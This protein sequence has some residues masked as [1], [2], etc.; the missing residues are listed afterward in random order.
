MQANYSETNAVTTFVGLP[1]LKG[2]STG[3]LPQSRL[4]EAWSV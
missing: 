2:F 1:E 4:A 3:H